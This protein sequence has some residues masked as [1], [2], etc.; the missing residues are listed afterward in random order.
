MIIEPFY[1]NNRGTQSC[2]YIYIFAAKPKWIFRFLQPF[3]ASWTTEI[4]WQL[5]SSFARAIRFEHWIYSARRDTGIEIDSEPHL[6]CTWKTSLLFTP[7]VVRVYKMWYKCPFYRWTILFKSAIIGYKNTILDER[8]IG[9]HYE[10][11]CLIFSHERPV[12]IMELGLLYG[13]NICFLISQV[14]P[15][16]SLGYLW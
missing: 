12:I 13:N 1:C 5:P 9:F 15:E 2:P 3:I 6:S 14:K 16:W 10:I 4:D 8:P 11:W 7:F